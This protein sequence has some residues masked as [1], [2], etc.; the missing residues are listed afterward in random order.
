MNKDIR[1]TLESA[2]IARG[3]DEPIALALGQ[4][5]IAWADAE[6][7][8]YRALVAYSGVNDAVAR[9]IFSGTRASTMIAFIRSIAHNTEMATDRLSDL[10]YVFAQMGAI[11]SMRDHVIHYI[12]D[13]FA[14]AED[15]KER[16]VSNVDRTSRYGKHF[17]AAIGAD[18]LGAMTW[19]LYGIAN[20]LNM[21]HGIR[22]GPF[23]PWREDYEDSEPT[24][25][26]Y[27]SL[28]PV[29]NPGKSLAGARKPQAQ[30]KP[31]PKKR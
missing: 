24:P 14:F 27:K 19:D 6:K 16:Q 1:K 8:L 3:E 18:T 10:E 12:S 31:L 28:Q 7:E 15:P 5:V 11:L 23:R 9:A 13:S 21:H 29:D 30:R 25:W 22:E 20:H 26:R 2:F 17:T 4:F